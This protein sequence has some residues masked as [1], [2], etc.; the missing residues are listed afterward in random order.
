MMLHGSSFCASGTM[1]RAAG[2]MRLAFRLVFRAQIAGKQ[3]QFPNELLRLGRRRDR[4][5]HRR[6]FR[7]G[8][9]V[10]RVGGQFGIIEIHIHEARRGLKGMKSRAA[11]GMAGAQGF[12]RGVNEHPDMADREPGDFAD[13]LVAEVVLK[14][15]L[16][17]FLLPRREGGHD[18][19][20][21]PARFLAF[22]PFVRRGLVAFVF[23]EQSPRR[24]KSCAFPFGKC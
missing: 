22:D 9:F 7:A 14:L 2:R 5:F 4:G 23:F 15:E 24:D 12:E 13:L 19:E 20:E 8:E 3:A 21:K 16:Q 10:E 6:F 11:C 18:P 1:L 17:H